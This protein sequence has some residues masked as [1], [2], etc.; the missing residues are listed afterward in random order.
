MME[1]T[2]GAISHIYETQSTDMKAVL[3]IVELK[4]ISSNNNVNPSAPP[5][6][7][8]V[9]S[10]GEK[11]QDAMLA[12][13][14]NQRVVNNEVKVNS[15]IRLEDYICNQVGTKR[16]IIILR[17]ELLSN[18]PSRIGM[19]APV[20]GAKPSAPKPAPSYSNGASNGAPPSYN[21]SIPPGNAYGATPPT[22]QYNS[23]SAIMSTVGR[24]SNSSQNYRPIQ[25]INP[26]Q[27]GWTVRGRCTYKADL[28]RFQNQ[29][30]EGQVI[31]FE[32][33]DDSGSIRITAFTELAP[34]VEETVRMGKL[35][36]VTR[37]NLKHA[38]ERY[39]R[40]TS[41]YEMTLDS[42]SDFGELPD[43]GNV[44]KVKYNFTKIAQL[45]N[46]P[47][48]G[49][50]DVIGVVQ[51]VG[52]IGEITLRSTGEPCTKRNVII[53]DDSNASVEMTL[54]RNQAENFLKE[55]DANRHPILLIKGALRGDFGGVC[56][57]VSRSTALELDP[58]NVP[59][60]DQLRAWFDSSG[61]NT[62][63][64]TQLTASRGGG[65]KVS[66]ERKTLE[67]ARTEDIDPVFTGAGGGQASFTM[68]GF[69]SFIRSE[70]ELS[71]PSDPDT[72]KKVA[73][74]SPGVWHSPS[75]DRQLRDDEVVHRYIMS[76]KIADHTGSQW[77]TAFDEAGNVILNKGAGE[78]RDMKQ[79]D[80]SMFESVIDDAKFRPLLMNVKV[81]EDEYKG[82]VRLRYTINRCEM[83]DFA[84]E[85]RQLLE[86]IKSYDS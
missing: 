78:M 63:G 69:V 12:T 59:E 25:S 37:G 39:N 5:R 28:R 62:Q 61:G 76:L 51:S 26:Y 9:V 80:H 17:F 71:Y 22:R 11:S 70:N 19:P 3:Q 20:E 1:L 18:A 32:L 55:E 6:F 66:G 53:C 65:G 77:F 82:E 68:R 41:Q 33:T 50:C 15:L 30:G 58:I 52:P 48:R 54:W 72:K 86:E 74:V 85:A 31:S 40:S 47:N 34:R 83:L 67:E 81:R 24:S 79:N 45:E 56:L 57:N 13:Q 14:L 73:M 60:A 16:L 64:M 21:N 46:I 36:F 38:N 49:A 43:D 4:K 8:L 35:Y 84:S 29:R 75:T 44:I 27:N 42:R 23:S 10:D 7:R 2:R